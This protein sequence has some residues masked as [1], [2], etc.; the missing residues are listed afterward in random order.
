[1]EEVIDRLIFILSDKNLNGNEASVLMGIPRQT[2][3]K[4]TNKKSLPQ[5]RTLKL[6]AETMGVN[7]EWLAFGRKPIYTDP[8]KIP[9]AISVTSDKTSSQLHEPQINY[10]KQ[11]SEVE[12]LKLL[13]KEKDD[14]IEM[15]KDHVESLK[16][17]Y[18]E[19]QKKGESEPKTKLG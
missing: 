5:R 18:G 16:E 4:W 17:K 15:L 2:V 7:Y 3:N 19:P 6:F 11:T 13:L 14:K 1:M 10:G 12:Y 9:Q 8:E